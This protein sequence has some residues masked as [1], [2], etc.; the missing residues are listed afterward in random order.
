MKDDRILAAKDFIESR[1]IIIKADGFE[2]YRFDAH[3]LSHYI[4][5]TSNYLERK[6]AEILMALNPD[7]LKN[8]NS[9][10]III[11]KP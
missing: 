7:V 6:I 9:I 4:S 10:E 11:K 5:P 3:Y 2:L 8:K 1:G